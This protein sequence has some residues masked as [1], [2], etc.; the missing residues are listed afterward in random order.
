MAD[1]IAVDSA[2]QRRLDTILAESGFAKRQTEAARKLADSDE[3]PQRALLQD[4]DQSDRVPPGYDVYS[5]SDDE[6]RQYGIRD[7]ETHTWQR[8]PRRWE[9][10]EGNNGL[11]V[12]LREKPGRRV[13]KHENGDFVTNGDLVLVACPRSELVERDRHLAEAVADADY[14]LSQGD[15]SP[16]TPRFGSMPS[17]EDAFAKHEEHKARGFISD[18]GMTPAQFLAQAGSEEVA[19]VEAYYRNGGMTVPVPDDNTQARQEYE[20]RK[21]RVEDRAKGRRSYAVGA[22]FDQNGKIVR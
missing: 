21:A 22:G 16:S 20:D 14:R 15:V 2:L 13:I 17:K 5:L 18:H 11:A 10:I 3:A 7:H 6:R 9:P 12:W 4:G 8:N 1:A 19:R